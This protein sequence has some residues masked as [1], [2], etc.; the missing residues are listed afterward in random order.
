M[1][2]VA[3]AHRALARNE[4]G[5][6]LSQPTNC[7]TRFRTDTS[8]LCVFDPT[9][10]RHRLQDAADW[11]TVPQVAAVEMSAGNAL[12]FDLGSD[13]VYSIEVR[14]A[15]TAE[16]VSG[17]LRCPSGSLYFGDFAT[18]GGVE[19]SPDQDVILRVDPGDYVVSIVRN[20][21]FALVATL[22]RGADVRQGGD[23]GFLR[24]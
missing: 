20:G 22:V 5:V 15:L 21:L 17:A 11:W 1:E 9:C 4:R 6:Y 24:V 13:G 18:A 23:G 2:G 12:F 14:S 19:P 3:L 7:E 8:T 16:G 10:L